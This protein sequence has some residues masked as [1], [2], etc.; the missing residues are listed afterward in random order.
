MRDQLEIWRICNSSP[1][2]SHGPKTTRGIGDSN[3]IQLKKKKK[4][5]ALGTVVSNQEECLS[6]SPE[7][8]FFQKAVFPKISNWGMGLGQLEMGREVLLYPLGTFSV[9]PWSF[10]LHLHENTVPDSG[11]AGDWP[12]STGRAGAGGLEG[13]LGDHRSEG[14]VF[15]SNVTVLVKSGECVQ[16]VRQVFVLQNFTEPFICPRISK[17]GI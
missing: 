2:F 11:L 13:K 7:D 8:I 3:W 15:W 9:I 4:L 14:E 1:V 10:S 12:Q 6:K 5:R 16:L 17:K